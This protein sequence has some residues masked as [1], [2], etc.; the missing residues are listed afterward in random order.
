LGGDTRNWHNS[1][2]P[3]SIT[4]KDACVH[5]FYSKYFHA[6]KIHAMKID[7]QICSRKERDNTSSL[8][9]GLV[10]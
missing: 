1:L 2:P 10:R 3:K 6:D 7:M 4:S 8:G 9:G 5:L